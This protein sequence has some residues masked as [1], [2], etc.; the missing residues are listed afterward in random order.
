[1][2]LVL[3][4]GELAD[5]GVPKAYGTVVE[6]KE[7]EDWS[8]LRLQLLTTLPRS[9]SVERPDWSAW[10]LPSLVCPKLPDWRRRLLRPIS[11]HFPPCGATTVPGGSAARALISCCRGLNFPSAPVA[12]HLRPGALLKIVLMLISLLTSSML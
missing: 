6:G 5:N 12:Q 10:S 2:F 1:M 4:D 9:S 7:A 11:C 8:V 3:D